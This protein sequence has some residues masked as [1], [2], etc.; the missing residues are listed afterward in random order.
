MKH[1]RSLNVARREEGELTTTTPD[2][3][4]KQKERGEIPPRSE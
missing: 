1:S 4:Q 3:V 2:W